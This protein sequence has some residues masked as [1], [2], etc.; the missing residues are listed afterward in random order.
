[1]LEQMRDLVRHKVYANTQLLTAIGSCP[2][3]ASDA[4]LRGLLHHVLVSNRFWLM[5]SLGRPFAFEQETIVPS[6]LAALRENFEATHDLELDWLARATTADLSGVIESPR[7]PGHRFTVA[8]AMTQICLHSQGHRAQCATRLRSLGGIPPTL[9][10][11]RWVMDG[12]PDPR[13]SAR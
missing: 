7:L 11:I 8:Q 6:T 5:L 12:S 4:E 13:S 9:D 2:A 3:A 1:M 10:Y